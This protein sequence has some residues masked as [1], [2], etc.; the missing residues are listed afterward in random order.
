[1]AGHAPSFLPLGE[2]TIYCGSS[3]NRRMISLDQALT[4]RP[5]GRFALSYMAQVWPC[6]RFGHGVVAEHRTSR[7]RSNPVSLP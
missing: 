1:M 3:A 7:A 6:V 4:R 5:L 2:T